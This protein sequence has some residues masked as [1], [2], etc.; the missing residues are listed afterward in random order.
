MAPIL[1]PSLVGAEITFKCHV[2]NHF[3]RSSQTVPNTDQWDWVA[4]RMQS[5]QLFVWKRDLKRTSPILCR[6]ENSYGGPSHGPDLVPHGLHVSHRMQLVSS[7]LGCSTP[8][9][10]TVLASRKQFRIYRAGEKVC[11]TTKY[12]ICGTRQ[13]WVMKASMRKFL[14]TSQFR[15]LSS[16]YGFF[17]CI[18]KSVEVLGTCKS[19][20]QL[21]QVWAEVSFWGT[22]V[23]VEGKLSWQVTACDIF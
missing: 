6:M 21:L 1:C 15:Y 5:W 9:L 13:L 2:E 7:S 3:L 18:L 10:E 16:L 22:Q 23:F 17:F 8:P 11:V 12:K 4:H 14:L 20:C 19:T